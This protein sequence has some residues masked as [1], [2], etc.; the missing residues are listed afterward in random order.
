MKLSIDFTLTNSAKLIL[1]CT[2]CVIWGYVI[3]LTSK[4]FTEVTALSVALIGSGAIVL[5]VELTVWI[6]R[7][8]VWLSVKK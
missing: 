2:N 1:L 3:L 6:A 7:G 8:L 5:L 4:P